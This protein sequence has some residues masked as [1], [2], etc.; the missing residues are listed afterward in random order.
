VSSRAGKPIVI[1]DYDATWPVTFSRECAAIFHACGRDSFVTIEHVGSTS[2]P[3]LAAKPI[4]DLMPGLRCLA[5]AAALIP[6]LMT[7]G[8]EYA[9]KLEHPSPDWGAGMPFRRYFRKDVGGER[10]F[11]MHMVEVGSPFWNDHIAFRDYLRSSPQEA[12]DYARLKRELAAAY[13][14]TLGPSSNRA[15]EYVDRK[16]PFIEAALQKARLARPTAGI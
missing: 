11:H 14:A 9:P 4:I 15:L 16:S 5:D 8:Y 6:K 13:N 2:V 1:A 12:T 7:I 3:G 10:A